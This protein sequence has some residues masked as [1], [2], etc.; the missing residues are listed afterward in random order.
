[1]NPRRILPILVVAAVIGAG[2][3]YYLQV[4]AD[5]NA[6][7]VSGTIEATEVQLGSTG[8]GRVTAVNVREGDTVQEDEVVA[9]VAPAVSARGSGKEMIHSPLAGVVL[10]RSYE[11]G[12][13]AAP[14]APLITVADLEDLTLTVYLP[15]DRYGAIKLG[16][17]YPVTVD[18]YPGERFTGTVTH[19]ADKA[20]FTPRNVQTSDSRKTTVFAIKL[21]LPPS[22]GK[23]KP[24]MPADVHFQNHQ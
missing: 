18:S 5:Q 19:I 11:P 4:Q 12:E 17:S 14:G 10:E 6:L 1:M 8:G 13:F 3:Y 9:E 22:G 24:G 2:V 7:T 15:E 16:Q 21:S 20:E 23:L